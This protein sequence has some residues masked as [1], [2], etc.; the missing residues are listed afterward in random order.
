M[1]T[2]KSVI[3]CASTILNVISDFK[4]ARK[5]NVN[6]QNIFFARY[7]ELVDYFVSETG[8]FFPD[9]SR[10]G[11]EFF[12]GFSE[13]LKKR[14]DSSPGSNRALI[15]PEPVQ[16]LA[17]PTPGEVMASLFYGL[18]E[19]EKQSRIIEILAMFGIDSGKLEQPVVTL[20]GGEIL[21]LNYAKNYVLAETASGM[22]ACN[23]LFWLNRKRYGLW[24]TLVDRYSSMNKKVTTVA[25][26]A[27]DLT[28]IKNPPTLAALDFRILLDSPEIV[29][30][31]VTFPAFHPQNRICYRYDGEQIVCAS[32][33]LITGDNGTGKS[34]FARMLAGVFAA[35]GDRLS[36]R[37]YN[38]SDSVRLL[39]QECIFQM[40]TQ[41][42]IEHRAAVFAAD[43]RAGD[44]AAENFSQME[45]LLRSF[46]LDPQKDRL[47]RQ[48]AA[49][50]AE[51]L[52]YCPALLL[53]DEPGWGL[54]ECAVRG[55][56][57]ASCWLAHAQ[58]TAVAVI[59]HQPETI[60]VIAG[61]LHLERVG[62]EEVFMQYRHKR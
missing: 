1:K 45:K 56:V 51:R 7:E 62:K 47:L 19:K 54:N 37:G 34:V 61:H 16:G 14:S 35:T 57:M 38:D 21:Q 32:P 33:L 10:P 30:P 39:F 3:S 31:E 42:I 13:W 25:V 48:K 52:V 22:L 2:E 23:P 11:A 12:R 53:L 59:S 44:I 49:L 40:F 46:G 4:I 36:V 55:L 24:D 17:F 29:F 18:G 5:M 6:L 41:G 43:S 8:I 15:L 9:L 28:A 50:I 27:A 20:S 26:R 58:N 60:G